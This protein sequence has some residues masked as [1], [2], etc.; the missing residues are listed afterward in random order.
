MSEK[1][2][3]QYTT[4]LPK[5]LCPNFISEDWLDTLRDSFRGTIDMDGSKVILLDYRNESVPENHSA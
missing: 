4:S 2:S 5:T 3:L 1:K